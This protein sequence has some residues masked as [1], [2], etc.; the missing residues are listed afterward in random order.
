[1][2][3]PLRVGKTLLEPRHL[4]SAVNLYEKYFLPLI[5]QE[6]PPAVLF[7]TMLLLVLCAHNCGDARADQ[8]TQALRA[9]DRMMRTH[10][11]DA[12]QVL[13]VLNG[14]AGDALEVLRRNRVVIPG[15]TDD[16]SA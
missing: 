4:V 11:G 9:V 16:L 6:E 12:A 5:V 3:D 14:K 2:S 15:V 10:K 8:L 1:M 13:G 7:A